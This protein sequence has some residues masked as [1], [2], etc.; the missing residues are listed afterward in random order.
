M[1]ASETARSAQSRLLL[2]LRRALSGCDVY[3]SDASEA[4]VLRIQHDPTV[5]AHHPRRSARL[6][7]PERL[8]REG[9]DGNHNTALDD[10]LSHA[11]R[12]EHASD[13]RRLTARRSVV[14]IFSLEQWITH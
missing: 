13:I 1:D 5:S 3:D 14:I 8:R 9:D 12:R 6:L 11:S 4:T 10:R 2:V 7:H